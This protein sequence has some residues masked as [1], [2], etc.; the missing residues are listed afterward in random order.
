MKCDDDER[1]NVPGSCGRLS[2]SRLL[3][4][5]KAAEF[6]AQNFRRVLLHLCQ[7]AATHPAHRAV[8]VYVRGSSRQHTTAQRHDENKRCEPLRHCHLKL[9]E[10]YR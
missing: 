8:L 2:L 9:Y 1:R 5:H 7:M 3:T 6:C 4:V 10:A